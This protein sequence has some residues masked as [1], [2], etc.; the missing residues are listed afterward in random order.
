MRL[1]G[2][3]RSATCAVP[4]DR[5][6]AGKV[7]DGVVAVPFD[8][9]LDGC[10]D[11]AHINTRAGNVQRGVQGLFVGVGEFVLPGEVDRHG[12]VGEPPST[13]TPMSRLTI[14]SPNVASSSRSG[15]A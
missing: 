10:A 1:R 3:G 15:V 14:A 13:W 7:H 9:L 2:S 8:D 4:S 12:G 11:L 6:V 5:A